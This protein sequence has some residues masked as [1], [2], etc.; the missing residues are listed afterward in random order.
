MSSGEPLLAV[1]GLSIGF[2]TADGG[3]A[4]AADD[5]SLSVA[6]GR[7]LGIVG[8]SGC[9]KSV[10]L[11]AL[12][13]IL[14]PPG[15]V[16]AGSARW[17]DGSDLF[18][19]SRREQ[20]AI[21]GRE[22]AMIF[23]DPQN[24]LNPVYTIGDQ[25]TEVLTTRNGLGRR[26]A[27]RQAVEL[28]ERVGIPAAPRRLR[29]YPHHLSGGMRQRVM[30]AIATAGDPLL[31]LADEPTTALDVTIQDQILGLLADLQAES[32][33]ALIIVSH[34]L[35]VIGQS[36]D[37]VAVMYAGRIV[38]TGDVDEVLSAPRHPY[39]AGLLAAVPRMPGEAGRGALSPIQGQPPVIT[40]LPRGCSFRPRCRYERDGCAE[41]AMTLDRPPDEHGSACPFVNATQAEVVRAER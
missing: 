15:R 31:L 19:L 28:L 17:H 24:S 20:R 23:Q 30:I 27:K 16:L 9:G 8:E 21:R 14:P 32:G 2:P 10:T 29:D 34:D 12:L 13:G 38:E 36:C 22:I 18:R 40:D 11:R 39:T 7:T 6:R 5:V 3:H 41:I 37:R 35:G 4:L 1:Y 25:L 33:M 26:E